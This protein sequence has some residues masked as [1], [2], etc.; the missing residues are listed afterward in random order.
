LLNPSFKQRDDPLN[1][2]KQHE[3]T[4]PSVSLCVN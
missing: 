3:D 1:Y 4:P 2:T